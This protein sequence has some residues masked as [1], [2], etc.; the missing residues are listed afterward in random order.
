[1]ATEVYA[2]RLDFANLQG[3]RSYQFFKHTSGRS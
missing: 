1:V 3:E 2:K